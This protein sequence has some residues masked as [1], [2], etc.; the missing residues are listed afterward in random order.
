[1]TDPIIYPPHFMSMDVADRVLQ[2]VYS[3]NDVPEVLYWDKEWWRFNGKAWTGVDKEEIEGELTRHLQHVYYQSKD[4]LKPWAPTRNRISEIVWALGI[5][6]RPRN[7]D[8]KA[9]A[10]LGGGYTTNPANLIVMNNGILD[11]H[12][13]KFQPSHTPALFTTWHLPFDYDP[14]AECPTFEAFLNSIFEHDPAGRKTVQEF[15]GY[16][17]SGRTDLQKALVIIGPAR[18]GKGTLSRTIQ[19]LVGL[20]NVAS[21][22]LK[23]IGSEFGLAELIGKQL[24]VVEDARNDYKDNPAT[25][26]RLLSIIGEDAVAVN[27]KNRDFWHGTL[28]TRFLIVSN[29]VFSLGDNSGAILSRFVSVKLKKSFKDNPD[30][31]LG[32]KINQELPGI[33]NWALAGLQRLEEQGKFT[34][35]QT[36]EEVQGLMN[37]LNSPVANFLDET[38]QFELTRN[39]E[40][41]VTRS[42]LHHAYKAWCEEVGAHPMKQVNFVQA[43][44]AV[45]P[46]IE[47]KNTAVGDLPKARRIFGIRKVQGVNS[48]LMNKQSA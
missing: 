45:D 1:M 30:P 36:M 28:P 8:F 35:P 42:E 13:R 25:V 19:Q 29:D 3:P 46:G 37:D 39:P 7:R 17:V 4:G 38:P 26:E 21:P 14:H 32:K 43:L 48:W 16:A 9:P 18:G 6:S 47:S 41:W 34:Q 12:T 11:F 23:D 10:W 33:F 5:T 40:D 22:R 20:S 27:R 24:A 31:D 2:D 44:V 15:A